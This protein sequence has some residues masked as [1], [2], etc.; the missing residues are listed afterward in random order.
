MFY[1]R[2]LKCKK[3]IKVHPFHRF[4]ICYLSNMVSTNKKSNPVC[5]YNDTRI[6]NL[7][8]DVSYAYLNSKNVYGDFV[9]RKNTKLG[10][11]EN[12]WF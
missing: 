6:L 10:K 2:I 11:T 5:F 8:W 1:I 12:V 9:K 4:Y 7:N 3:V